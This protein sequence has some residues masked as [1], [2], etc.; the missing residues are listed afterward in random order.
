MQSK[1]RKWLVPFAWPNT[2]VAVVM[3][4]LLI[5]QQ[6]LTAREFLRVLGY[7]LLYSNLVAVF[8]MFLIEV[9]APSGVDLVA[10]ARRDPVFGPVVV[11]GL[12]GIT[13]EAIADVA[14]RLA[15]LSAA[16]AALM[17]GELAARAL[18]D[19]WRGGPVLDPAEFG[20]VLAGLGGLLAA[21]PH[22]DEIEINPLRLSAGGL[23]ALDA[24][25]ITQEVT[26]AQ[27]DR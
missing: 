15:P 12:G 1:P 2:A 27:P 19:G 5:T 23:V 6:G 11:A 16:E 20:R 4:I 22:L 3:V 13:A 24:V 14:V 10:G 17:P 25:I 8:A 18:L 26:D 21:S 9:M 7:S